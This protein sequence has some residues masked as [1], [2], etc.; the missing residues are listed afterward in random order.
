MWGRRNVV[1]D[2]WGNSS[3]YLGPDVEGNISLVCVWIPIAV[4]TKHYYDILPRTQ[5]KLILLDRT[6]RCQRRLYL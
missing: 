5:R 2:S 1:G 4:V 6:V 3:C